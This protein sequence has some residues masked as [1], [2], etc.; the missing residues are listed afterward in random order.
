MAAE[1]P[2][3]KK[4]VVKTHMKILNKLL[5]I[6]VWKPIERSGLEKLGS[7]LGI[8]GVEIWTEQ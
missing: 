3:K 1:H 7:I 4:K 8:D 5:N 2:K 6:L